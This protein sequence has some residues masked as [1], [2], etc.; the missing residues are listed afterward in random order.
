MAASAGWFQVM[1]LPRRCRERAAWRCYSVDVSDVVQPRV[2]A[3]RGA[4]VRKVLA[5]AVSLGMAAIMVQLLVSKRADLDGGSWLAGA[6]WLVGPLL[7]AVGIWPR[8]IGLQLVSRAFWW[9]QLLFAVLFSVF[10]RGE[11]DGRIVALA[12]GSAGALLLAGRLGLADDGSGRFRPVAFRGTLM[13]ALVLAISDVGTFFWVGTMQILRD[14][15]VRV[16]LFVPLMIAG[17]IG[18]LRLRTWGLIVSVA[19]NVLV[20]VL[21]WTPFF[22]MPEGFSYIVVV[23]AIAQLLI[24][25]PIWI[26]I[27]RRRA[28]PPD[29]WQKAKAIASTSVILLFAALAIA[30]KLGFFHMLLKLLQQVV[31]DGHS[32]SV[33]A[34]VDGAFGGGIGWRRGVL[35]RH[36]R[37]AALCP[38]VSG[39]GR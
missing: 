6:M 20:A 9:A 35:R 39:R 36:Q 38:G 5:S 34:L 33:L 25:L 18:L 26:A 21:A 7:A 11:P 28:P 23:T 1:P 13:L 22:A 32:L 12:L 30:A 3:A 31:A 15:N 19:C 8:A 10:T 4:A 24:P 27:I 37:R 17:V 2:P 14:G 29:R 16:I